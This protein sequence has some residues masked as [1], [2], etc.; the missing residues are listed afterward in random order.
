MADLPN[1]PI[2]AMAINIVCNAYKNGQLTYEELN[3]EIGE[4]FAVMTFDEMVRF[5]II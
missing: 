3:A 5:K 1:R 2:Y 4:V